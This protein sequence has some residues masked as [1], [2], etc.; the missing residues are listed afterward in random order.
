VPA[1]VNLLFAPG[2][3]S[4]RELAA[5][6]ARRVSTGSLLFR[7]ALGTALETAVAVRDAAPVSS[8]AP[9]YDEVQNLVVAGRD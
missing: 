1:P 7:V 2:R 5:L 3:Q 9:G 8:G 4:V 6:G